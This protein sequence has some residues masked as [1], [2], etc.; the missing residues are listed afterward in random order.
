MALFLVLSITNTTFFEPCP[1]A[2]LLFRCAMWRAEDGS[3]VFFSVRGQSVLTEHGLPNSRLC[4]FYPEGITECLLVHCLKGQSILS[5][6]STAWTLGS[7]SRPKRKT[8]RHKIVKTERDGETRLS[9]STKGS[10]WTYRTIRIKQEKL[11]PILNQS[12]KY[13][14]SAIRKVPYSACHRRKELTENSGQDPRLEIE[15]F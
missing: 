3:L 8:G 14:V 7:S 11:R 4:I 6:D 12:S 5:V 15:T 9:K 2:Q 10:T 1:S 13:S